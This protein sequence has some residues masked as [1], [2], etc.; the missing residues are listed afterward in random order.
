[1][2][3]LH[4]FT[5][6]AL[7]LYCLASLFIAAPAQAQEAPSGPAAELGALERALADAMHAKDEGRLDRLLAPDYVLRG[8]PD[9][10]RTTWLRNALALCWGDRSEIDNLQTQQHAGVAVTSFELTFHVDPDTCRP[11]ELRSLITDVWVRD[12]TGWRLQVRHAGPPPRGG[13]AAQYGAVPEV[14]PVWDA[15]GELSLVAT[16]GTTSVRTLGLGSTV[17]HRGSAT[18]TLGSI[19]FLTSEVEAV[20]NARSLTTLGRHGRR[21]GARVELFGEASYGRD[22]FAGIDNRIR[23]AAGAAYSASLRRRQTLTAEGTVGYTAEN[24]LD[25]MD[26]RFPTATGTLRYRWSGLRGTELT[27]DAGVIADLGTARNWR[28]TSATAFVVTLTR[29]VSFKVAHALEYRNDPVRGF[30]RTDLETTAAL[31]VSL[32]RR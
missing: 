9:I 15:R 27:E 13:I 18:T 31:V 12:S 5:R 8:S 23:A 1:M 7:P 24:R 16:G 28:G 3:S 4:R 19:A 29:L 22:R 30:G 26:R 2:S 10:D 25:S 11:A 6:L 14:P 20:T 32:Q 17:V 21:V